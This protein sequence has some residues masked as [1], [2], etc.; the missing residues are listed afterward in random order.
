MSSKVS[1]QSS[2]TTSVPRPIGAADFPQMPPQT[3]DASSPEEAILG[4]DAQRKKACSDRRWRRRGAR[5]DGR[6]QTDGRRSR[7][8]RAALA[9][10]RLL[11]PPARGRRAL[12]A[13]RGAPLRPCD[14]GTWMR[15]HAS[16][17]HPHLRRCGRTRGSHE[18]K[19]DLR[20]RLPAHRNRR[21]TARG[22]SGRPD[23]PWRCRCLAD[24]RDAERHRPRPC[25]ALGLRA[26]GRSDLAA[27]ALRA[28][29]ADRRARPGHRPRDHRL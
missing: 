7:R 4:R 6:T 14:L 21:T 16:S 3:T 20:V 5:G 28:R 11:L 1:T 9:G 19:R 13:G 18:S 25:P 24:P 23:L 29:I 2:P 15:R 26:S 17:R 12:R 10:S 8:R 27:P 22:G